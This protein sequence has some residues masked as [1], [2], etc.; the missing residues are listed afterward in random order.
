MGVFLHGLCTARVWEDV[1]TGQGA[2]FLW[3]RASA[4][5][6]SDCRAGSELRAG[7]RLVLGKFC[8]LIDF[9]LAPEG[10]AGKIS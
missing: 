5:L 7:M 4:W 6:G 10:S 9:I 1:D 8:H 2:R 3:P